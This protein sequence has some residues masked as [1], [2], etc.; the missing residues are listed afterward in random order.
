MSEIDCGLD[1]IL[2][3]PKW[4]QVCSVTQVYATSAISKAFVLAQSGL[5][6][7]IIVSAVRYATDNDLHWKA[8]CPSADDQ[9]RTSVTAAEYEMFRTHSQKISDVD[10]SQSVDFESL[11]KLVTFMITD[12]KV[13][14]VVIS[15]QTTLLQVTAAVCSLKRD[16]VLLLLGD[17]QIPEGVPNLFVNP[18]QRFDD[19]I[20][21]FTGFKGLVESD[22]E[23]IKSIIFANACDFDFVPTDLPSCVIPRDDYSPLLEASVHDNLEISSDISEVTACSSFAVPISIKPDNLSQSAR[24]A[25]YGKGRRNF[26]V[27]PT[28]L[29]SHYLEIVTLPTFNA[30]GDPQ[31]GMLDILV[32]VT[33]L[34]LDLRY[35]SVYHPG[36]SVWGIP[37]AEAACSLAVVDNLEILTVA[38]SMLKDGGDLIMTLPEPLVVSNNCASLIFRFSQFFRQVTL[39]RSSAC[40]SKSFILC[41]GLLH[42]KFKKSK[43][44][45]FSPTP[46]PCLW[47][48]EFLS[49]IRGFN[50]RVLRDACRPRSYGCQGGS[51]LGLK[52]YLGG[53]RVKVGVY[54]GSFDP[55]HE[56]HAA[57]VFAAEALGY[58]VLLV[59]NHGANEGKASLSAQNHREEMLKIRFGHRVSPVAEDTSSWEVKQRIAQALADKLLFDTMEIPEPVLLLG[60]DSFK[61]GTM[62]R[63]AGIFK[64]RIPI[65]VFPRSDQPF[66]IPDELAR[67]VIVASD[68]SDPS[69]GLSSS[70]IRS[71]ICRGEAVSSDLLHESVYGYI[72]DH[73]LYKDEDFDLSNSSVLMPD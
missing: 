33:H 58:K 65:V 11:E 18:V 51:A 2:V 34:E 9:S 52:R 25:Y 5:D 72:N 19:D 4:I 56:N 31:L 45:F 28:P 8:A 69:P 61:K 63:A 40:P 20:Y 15:D 57:L 29:S 17:I 70:M 43:A 60:E 24:N 30:P 54:F 36:G 22:R 13:D 21:L 68:Y 7:A 16:G 32:N 10:L 53:E 12:G 67:S 39:T 64:L 73:G 41:R 50:Q 37:A 27:N 49:V 46:L 47:D 48:P 55:P 44:V 59:P 66:A 35:D 6:V 62:K 26:Q 14:I 1:S 42:A 23:V 71:K 3:S 38:I